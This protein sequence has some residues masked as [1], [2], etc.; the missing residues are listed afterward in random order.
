MAHVPQTLPTNSK[1]AGTPLASRHPLPTSPPHP[2]AVRREGD[3]QCEGA[4]RDKGFLRSSFCLSVAGRRLP[5]QGLAALPG[6]AAPA[7][8]PWGTQ[9]CP[10]LLPLPAACLRS[11]PSRA[12]DSHNLRGAQRASRAIV[13]LTFI[14]YEKKNNEFFVLARSRNAIVFSSSVCEISRDQ[15]SVPPSCISM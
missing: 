4:W 3:V 5:V 7:T 15:D 2:P 6:A 12:R 11:S 9:G 8:H 13:V 10:A 1:D 14:Y